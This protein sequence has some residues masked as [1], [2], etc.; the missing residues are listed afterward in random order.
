MDLFARGASARRRLFA[1]AALACSDRRFHRIGSA[2][3]LRFIVTIASRHLNI[4]LM[5]LTIA[6]STP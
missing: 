4:Q 6:K 1:P 2:I 5:V 3:V